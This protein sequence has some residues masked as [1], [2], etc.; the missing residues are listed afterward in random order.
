[1][2]FSDNCENHF[3]FDDSEKLGA[4]T[5]TAIENIRQSLL[6][7]TSLRNGRLPHEYWF[8]QDQ[9][10]HAGIFV[11]NKTNALEDEGVNSNEESKLN[12]E[13]SELDFQ[14]LG[15]AEASE[16][17]HASSTQIKSDLIHEF[18]GESSL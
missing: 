3:Y 9:Q 13:A 5:A 14:S 15:S 16:T 11:E 8:E 6:E 17:L 18:S 2:N 10:Q 12:F 4:L 7:D 1:M